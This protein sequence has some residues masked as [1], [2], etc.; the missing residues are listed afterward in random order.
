MP[1]CH[2]G[3]SP[4]SLAGPR[5]AH[6]PKPLRARLGSQLL[7]HGFPR[8]LQGFTRWSSPLTPVAPHSAPVGT[9]LPASALPCPRCW[10]LILTGSPAC[11]GYPRPQADIPAE[12]GLCTPPP[13]NSCPSV[14]PELCP[15]LLR[16]SLLLHV[17]GPSTAGGSRSRVILGWDCPGG[18]SP[19]AFCAGRLSPR[20]GSGAGDRR[21]SLQGQGPG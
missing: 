8:V 14:L 11:L 7:S 5:R 15:A 10:V 21:L 17:S 1:S 6:G 20:E 9:L 2:L 18:P 12:T 16:P 19:Q 13:P 4:A 3:E